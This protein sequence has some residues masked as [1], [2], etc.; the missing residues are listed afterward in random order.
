MQRPPAG[1]FLVRA[2]WEDGSFRARITCCLDINSPS[3]PRTGAV[4]AEPDEV[5]RLLAAWLRD[6]EQV[7]GE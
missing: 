5:G 3:E 1:V 7:T 2:W 4:T 6:F